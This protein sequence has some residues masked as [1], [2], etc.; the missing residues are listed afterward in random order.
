MKAL[1]LGIAALLALTATY[2]SSSPVG[3]GQE[4]SAEERE[5][6]VARGS[7]VHRNNCLMCHSSELVESQ[8]LTKAQWEAEVAK[9]V[10]WGA[11]VAKEEEADLLAF[12]TTSF[13]SD[14][15]IPAPIR[16]P[17]AGPETDREDAAVGSVRDLRELEPADL[18]RGAKLF[19]THCASCHG[20]TAL[21]GD[22]G[23]NLVEK[24]ILLR[25]KV[26]REVVR[27]GRNKMPSFESVLNNSGEIDLLA[28]LARLPDAA[29]R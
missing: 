24:P 12:L 9:M 13:G 23:T 5:E 14:R 28:W 15:P 17:V 7:L 19:A 21:G 16:R 10:G 1:A 11:P 3:R 29:S 27:K 22:V 8:R 4:T 18:G 2:S 20:P 26:F 6:A 25:P